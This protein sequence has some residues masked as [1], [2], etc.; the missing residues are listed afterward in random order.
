MNATIESNSVGA[1]DSLHVANVPHNNIPFRHV[2]EH[3]EDP[4]APRA[5]NVQWRAVARRSMVAVGAHVEENM[6]QWVLFL[7]HSLHIV[8]C[9]PLHHVHVHLRRRINIPLA[10]S[11]EPS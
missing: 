5:L 4:D 11:E 2:L 9:P 3:L 6:L 8:L 10:R 1:A 7:E